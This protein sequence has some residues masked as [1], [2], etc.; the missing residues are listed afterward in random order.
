MKLFPYL[1][2]DSAKNRNCT[3]QTLALTAHI[4]AEDDLVDGDVSTMNCRK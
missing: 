1:K 2:L 3:E 4:E